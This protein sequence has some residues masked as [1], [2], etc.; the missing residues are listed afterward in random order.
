MIS[1]KQH[2]LTE[3]STAVKRNTGHI[4]HLEDQ[5][6]YGGVQGAREALVALRSMR[7]M[8]AGNS[9]QSYDI[10]AKFDGAPAIFV[11]TDPTDGKFFVAK[12]GI[13]NKN[14]KV[15]KTEAEVRADTSGDLAEKLSIALRYFSKLGIKGILQGDL[16]YTSKDL[17]VEKFDDVEYLTFQPNTIVYAI[18]VDSDLAKTIKASKIG[19]MFHTQY[20]GKTFESMKASYGFDSTVLK[21]TPDVWFSDTYIRDLSGKA[22]LT[23][24]E[25]AH[26]TEILS[27]AGTIFQKISGNA[28]RELESN[29]TLAQTL[30]T[31]NNT[32]VR[33]GEQIV[34]AAAHVRNLL[35]W[36]NAK[37]AKEADT[38]KSE[39]GKA[40][41]LAKR[42]EFLKFFSSENKVSLERIYEL[43]NAI[44]EAKLIIIHKLE[45]LKKM[46][47]F[48]RT[49]NGFRVTGQEGFA[50]NDHIKQNVVKLVDRMSF[51]KN[52]FDPEIL[53]GWEK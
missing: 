23:A 28:L 44:V 7:D 5:V 17:K 35:T 1:F 38:K 24:S 32:L 3:A 50:I 25:T 27:R 18:P 8:L 51:S 49:A 26:L 16:A 21:K 10:A 53:K 36:I 33:R 52:N 40:S 47:T 13:F 11:G 12:K 41:T 46:S 6:L 34:D 19:V 14:P 15:Y 48:I 2:Y 39:A 30:E 29:P 42:D 43:Q 37:Y 20:T 4:T 45:T 31:F 22:T 9:P